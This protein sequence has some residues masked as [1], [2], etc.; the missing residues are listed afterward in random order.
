MTT[1]GEFRCRK[2]FF[3]KNKTIF[4]DSLL[5]QKLNSAKMQIFTLLVNILIYHS[6]YAFNKFV[7]FS[8]FLVKGMFIT[9]MTTITILASAQMK[10]TFPSLKRCELVGFWLAV[11]ALDDAQEWFQWC[12]AMVW[13]GSFIVL[14]LA[15]VWVGSVFCRHLRRG[16]MEV[17]EKQIWTCLLDALQDRL[18]GNAVARCYTRPFLQPHKHA[19]W[20]HKRS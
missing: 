1:F 7:L 20:D 12:A 18:R 3:N 9:K 16:G 8:R 11:N 15:A 17:F 13:T 19:L 4:E 14:V 5:T 10:I 2:W 6:A